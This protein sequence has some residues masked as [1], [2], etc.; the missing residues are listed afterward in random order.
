[1][2]TSSRPLFNQNFISLALFT[3]VMF[4]CNPLRAELDLTGYY[5]GAQ[6]TAA[7]IEIVDPLNSANNSNNS[8]GFLHG[9]FGKTLSDWVSIEASFAVSS[10]TNDNEDHDYIVGAYVKAG[11]KTGGYRLY[12]LI[13]ASAL[14]FSEPGYQSDTYTSGSFGAGIEIFGTNDMALSLEYIRLID[15]DKFVDGRDLSVD[16]LSLGFVYYFSSD[17]SRFNKNR[18]KIPS[19]RY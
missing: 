6:Y 4:V 15:N 1:M 7:D 11:K 19:I 13:G 9:K 10:P 17:T 18:D 2:K 16:T 12:G 14:S 3:S 5:A 8:W